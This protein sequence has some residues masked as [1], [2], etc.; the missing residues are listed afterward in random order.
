MS[1]DIIES[2]YMCLFF[3][4]ISLIEGSCVWSF[5]RSSNVPQKKRFWAKF[6]FKLFLVSRKK[7]PLWNPGGTDSH[8]FYA[9]ALEHTRFWPRC[10]QHQREHTSYYLFMVSCGF[11]H[12][13]LWLTLYFS[14]ISS[15]E[16]ICIHQTCTSSWAV[17]ALS[18]ALSCVFSGFQSKS[19]VSWFW[20]PPS[21]F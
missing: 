19:C 5:T 21:C 15:H 20:P 17:M 4:G 13:G 14:V 16:P 18:V 2:H 8:T 6:F 7:F 3:T 1:T 11:F 12:S 9:I 10:H